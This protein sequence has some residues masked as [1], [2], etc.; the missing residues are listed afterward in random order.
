MAP[1]LNVALYIR[2]LDIGIPRWDPIRGDPFFLDLFPPT[3]TSPAQNIFE[4]ARWD[5][6]INKKVE[7]GVSPISGDG[8]ELF[9]CVIRDYLCPD[10]FFVFLSFTKEFLPCSSFSI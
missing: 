3:S 1:L 7:R 8:V 4:R 9:E 10:D 6:K 2:N 5:K